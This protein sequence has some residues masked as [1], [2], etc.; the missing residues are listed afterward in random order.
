M[1][2][3]KYRSQDETADQPRHSLSPQASSPSSRRYH[4]SDPLAQFI[5]PPRF[6]DQQEVAAIRDKYKE[7]CKTVAKHCEYP[8]QWW[9]DHREEY[10]LLSKIVLDLLSL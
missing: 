9:R 2:E 6:Y 10:S 8:L 1:W 7:Y 5:A 3:E 4:E